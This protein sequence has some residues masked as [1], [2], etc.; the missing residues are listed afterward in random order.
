M[1]ECVI[2]EEDCARSVFEELYVASWEVSM[3]LSGREHKQTTL[4]RLFVGG[5]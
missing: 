1:V 3:L 2:C 5:K 4:A